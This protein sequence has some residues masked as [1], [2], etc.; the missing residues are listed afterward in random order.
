MKTQ[1]IAT[2]LLATTMSMSAQ[3]LTLED[4]HQMALEQNKKIAADKENSAA[5]EY[6][7]KAAISNFFP[8]VSAN[9]AYMYNQKNLYLVPDVVPINVGGFHIGDLNAGGSGLLDGAY[10][11]LYDALTLDIRHILVGQVG[12]TQPI[13]MGGKLVN[14]YRMT[15]TLKNISDIK[16]AADTKDLIIKVDEA[17]WRVVSV[18]QKVKLAHQYQ[19]LLRKLSDDVTLMVEEGVATKADL[20]KVKIKLNEADE[21]VGQAEDGLIL[22]RMALSELLGLEL[23]DVVSIDP[24]GIDNINLS[25]ELE[26]DEHVAERRSEIQILEQT[27]RIA[28]ATKNIAA[29]GLMPNIVAQ[30]NYIMTNKSAENG[31]NP[32]KYFGFFNAGVVVNIPIAHADAICRLKAAQHQ[33]KA[34]QLQLEEAKEMI[35]LQATQSRQKVAAAQRKLLRTQTACASAEEVLRMAKEGFEEG[36]ISSTELMGAETQWMS[37]E[38]DRIDAIIELRMAELTYRKHTGRELE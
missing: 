15:K 30:G 23:T 38:S 26:D 22:S 4:C 35:T 29:A 28:K 11:K 24:T 1:L 13:F 10:T 32:N 12:V 27:E 21:K 7:R 14:A 3:T 5:A 36:V 9:G 34:V 19:D 6:M 33:R 17:Y 25:Y 8:R 37:A 20:L 18:Q 31:L 2:I 16:T